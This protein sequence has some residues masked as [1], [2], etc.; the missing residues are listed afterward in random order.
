MIETTI[1]YVRHQGST[2][3]KKIYSHLYLHSIALLHTIENL[4]Y[5]S[6]ADAD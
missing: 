4:Q 5:I 3:Y 2:Y 1:A 6:E